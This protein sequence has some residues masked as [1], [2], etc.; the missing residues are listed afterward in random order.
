MR[1]FTARVAMLIEVLLNSRQAETVRV[2]DLLHAVGAAGCGRGRRASGEERPQH[3]SSMWPP[4]PPMHSRWG[5]HTHLVQ[6]WIWRAARG[7]R[8][9]APV[10]C[11][12]KPA[13]GCWRGTPQ[14]DQRPSCPLVGAGRC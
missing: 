2:S 14:R 10:R 12:L 3:M 9:V 13:I 6:W 8:R 4:R 7:H 5:I 1:M 11:A